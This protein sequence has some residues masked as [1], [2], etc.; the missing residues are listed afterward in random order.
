MEM[1]LLA[2]QMMN[3]RVHGCRPELSLQF[4]WYGLV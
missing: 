1:R 3:P 2:E 4:Q